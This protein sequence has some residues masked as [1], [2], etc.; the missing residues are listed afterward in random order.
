MAMKSVV[1]P[2]AR[3]TLADGIY[4]QLRDLISSAKL[5][6]GEK[7]VIDTLAKQ[8][9][10]SI[11]PVREALRR[12]EREGLVTEAPY[13]GMVV[14]NFSQHELRELFTV[15]GV[16]E[17][18]AVA[19]ACRVLTVDDLA[20][21]QEQLDQLEDAARAGDLRRFRRLNTSFHQ[22]ILSHAPSRTLQRMIADLARN[23]DR[24][25]LLDSDMDAE[26]MRAAQAEHRTLVDLLRRRRAADAE[27]LS[28][29]HALTFVE[30]LNLRKE[31]G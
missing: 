19:E 26:Y 13:K 10:V 4:D 11:T 1:Q 30:H 12:L 28:R 31:Q 16:L 17:G 15:R 21:I 8:F 24:Y 9:Q 2:S 22:L 7:L 25:R 14:S 18:Y 3:K 27:R 20:R 29:R 5:R 23:T 6:P